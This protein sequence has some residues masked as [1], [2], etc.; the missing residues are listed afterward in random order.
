MVV[1]LLFLVVCVAI[2]CS[3]IGYP[4]E[5]EWMEG[6]CLLQVERALAGQ[7]LYP[8]PSSE[9]IPYIYPPVFLYLFA[10]VS[11]LIGADFFSLRLVSFLASWGTFALIYLFVKRQTRSRYAAVIALC[12]YAATFR[13]GGAWLDI[14]R[15]D[16][17]HLFLSLLAL[18]LIRF[19]DSVRILSLAGVVIALAF[20]TKQTVLLIF[21][22]VFLYHLCFYR[23][24]SIPMIG[25]TIAV[26]ALSIV[27]LDFVYDRWYTF[28][29]FCLPSKH[30]FKQGQL[31]RF[32]KT[33]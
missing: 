3:R 24:P 18:Y 2:V 10:L 13:I 12:M 16:T 1:G 8:R 17:L 23:L 21:L 25:T 29:V 20:L 14:A 26:T 22:P 6:N 5:L 28:Y 30:G 15:V 31:V 9:Y 7:V 27:T 4:F 11:L 32:S 19:Y 33:T